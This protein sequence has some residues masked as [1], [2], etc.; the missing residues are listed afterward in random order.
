[1]L[2]SFQEDV[3]ASGL[4]KRKG[5]VLVAMGDRRANPSVYDRSFQGDVATS[6][7]KKQKG[8][9]SVALGEQTPVSLTANEQGLQPR[10]R[11][12]AL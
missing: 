4:R 6:S 10:M 12:A 7:H 11:N 1:M 2:R 3:A 9:V 5:G 8:G